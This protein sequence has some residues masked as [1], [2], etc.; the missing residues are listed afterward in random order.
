MEE[1]SRNHARPRTDARSR[2]NAE[3]WPRQQ[4]ESL[5]TKN[6]TRESD[7][8]QHQRPA[9]ESRHNSGRDIS[10]DSDATQGQRSDYE[11]MQRSQRRTL[12][13]QKA[14]MMQS[15]WTTDDS[16]PMD[17]DY[18]EE[19]TQR[20]DFNFSKELVTLIRNVPVLS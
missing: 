2:T 14:L 9:Y 20:S 8:I 6:M 11:S 4:L 17:L 3:P 5:D 16:P 1:L 13:E 19:F 10:S 18:D 7:A 15:P 12:Q